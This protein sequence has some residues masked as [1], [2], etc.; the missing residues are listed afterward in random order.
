MARE[1]ESTE[2][3]LGE[4]PKT[5][6]CVSSQAEDPSHRVVP[7][8]GGES[9][10]ATLGQLRRILASMPGVTIVVST[11]TYIRAEFSSRILRFVDDLELSAEPE[12]GVVHVRSASRIG[13][14]DFGANRRRVEH[15]RT[16]MARV[17]P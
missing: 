10:E 11:D 15:L 1:I 16:R 14:W 7:F 17:Q 8:T 5:P 12:E 3:R 13:T 2:P 9:C 4:C 6:N